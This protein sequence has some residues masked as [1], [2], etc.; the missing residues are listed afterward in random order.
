VVIGPRFVGHLRGLKSLKQRF[1][2]AS[3]WGQADSFGGGHVRSGEY[4]EAVPGSP[5][6]V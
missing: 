3:A 1:P 4:K 5:I 6:R 2:E